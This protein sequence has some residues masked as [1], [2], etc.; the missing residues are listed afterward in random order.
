MDNLETRKW[1]DK[2]WSKVLE[3]NLGKPNSKIDR[4]VNSKVLSIRYAIFTQILGKIACNQRSILSL[5]MGDK[6]STQN[7]DARSFCTSVIVPWVADNND[8]LGKSLD[9]YVNNP[10]RRPRL[11]EDTNNLRH[12]SEWDSLVEYLS[13]LD[14]ASPK[15]LENSFI[16]CLESASRRLSAQTFSYLIPIRVS[17]SQTIGVLEKF[18]AENSGGFR[19]LVV[20]TAIMAIIGRSF[21]L[22]TTV[23][24]QGLNQADTSSGA[25]GDIMC[26]DD[27]E[28]MI[29]A[30][31]VKDRS[32]TLADVR[33]TE[34]KVRASKHSLNNLIFAT[35]DIKV[36]ERNGIEKNIETAWASGLNMNQISI[37]N[38][39]KV[40]LALLS[41][42]WRPKLLHEIGSE[43]DSR[44]D[45][46]HR[47][48][49]R[50]LLTSI[51][52]N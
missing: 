27:N 14:T 33:T 50:D 26:F 43:L 40:V 37:I 36:A 49:W 25:P 32:L 16:S 20:S 24:S 52:K 3:A 46:K 47:I 5:Q 44:A 48:A 6:V 12:K 35:P 34:L 17:M 15:E 11:D 31:E 23:T 42:D 2:N 38:L 18:L 13:P 8:V 29:L 1:L 41:E 45:H 28:N 10:L 7:W 19:P 22:Y 51:N 39:T 4:L 21:S 30:V 9:P